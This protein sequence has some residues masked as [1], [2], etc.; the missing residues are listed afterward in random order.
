MRDLFLALY[1]RDLRLALRRP[2]DALLPLVFCAAAVSLFPLAVGP[3]PQTLRLMAPGVVWACAL[4]AALL[5]LTQLYAGDRAD[6]TLEQMLLAGPGGAVV[7]AAKAAAHWSV[8]GL[9]LVL[10]APLLGLLLGLRGATLGV[11][12]VSLLLGTPVLSLLGNVAAALTVGLRSAGLL[13]VLLV[14]PLSV[15][16]LVFGTGAVAAAEGG[17][18]PGAHCSLLGALLIVSVLT[19]LPAAGAALRI[20][21][22]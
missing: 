2:V 6:G 12:A 21:M 16:A 19:A 11:L 18:S 8:T 7:A 14:L 9:P 22:E 17:Q 4:L 5:S 10:L 13:I 1:L 20:S 15:P 3:E